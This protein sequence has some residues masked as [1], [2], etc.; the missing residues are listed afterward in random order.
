MLHHVGCDICVVPRLLAIFAQFL[1]RLLSSHLF[2]FLSWGKPKCEAAAPCP[3]GA[4]RLGRSS[5]DAPEVD[6]LVGGAAVKTQVQVLVVAFLHGVHDLLRHPHREGQVAADL[7]HDD[8]RP[9][10]PCLDFHVLPRNLLNHAQG[11]RP[12]AV[13]SVLR[14]VGERVLPWT[15]KVFIC[16]GLCERFHS[17]S[18][19]RGGE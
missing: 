10:V 12:V 9:D 13:P 4:L 17:V 8:G 11:V 16:E 6:A 18:R 2:H 14:A 3:A 5:P 1:S 7:P 19:G 15:N